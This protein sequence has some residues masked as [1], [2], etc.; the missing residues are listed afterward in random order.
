MIQSAKN[1]FRLKLGVFLCPSWE[2]PIITSHHHIICELV[3]PIA[4]QLM[5]QNMDICIIIY[6]T[7]T[8][9]KPFIKYNHPFFTISIREGQ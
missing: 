4:P 2:N 1:V 7:V 6:Y 9:Q 5:L 8:I 3:Q